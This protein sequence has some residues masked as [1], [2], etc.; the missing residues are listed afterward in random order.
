[1]S[2]GQAAGG[3][4]YPDLVK[5]ETRLELVRNI[6]C[7]SLFKQKRNTVAAVTRVRFHDN[8]CEMITSQPLWCRLSSATTAVGP[9]S[10]GRLSVLAVDSA[11][12]QGGLLVRLSGWQP[13]L[14]NYPSTLQMFASCYLDR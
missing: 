2:K 5:L 1:M 6:D 3:P 11:D 10:A 13:L 14:N 4:T 7:I 12:H 8:V 9:Q